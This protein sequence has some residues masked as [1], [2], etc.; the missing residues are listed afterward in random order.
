MA[1]SK[2]KDGGPP[3]A[4]VI[5]KGAGPPLDGEVVGAGALVSDETDAPLAD[6]DGLDAD[7]PAAG[8]DADEKDEDS[9]EFVVSRGYDDAP[10]HDP[11][12][13]TEALDA[14]GHGP[15][16]EDPLGTRLGDFMSAF[17]G[18]VKDFMSRAFDMDG[19]GFVS[20]D[21]GTHAPERSSPVPATTASA[22][23]DLIHDDKSDE[24]L[25]GGP[26]ID[27]IRG[28]KG[29]D[30]LDGA[31]G[32]DWLRGGHGDDVLD[33]GAGSD[34][35]D[36]GK[37][38]DVL[39]Y[40][41]SENAGETDHYD[42][43]KGVDTLRL[44]L[45][46]AEYENLKD[47]LEEL[48]AWIAET[49][50]PK[51]SES[52]GFSDKSAH[53]AKHPV[54]ETSFGLTVRNFE[55]LEVNIVDTEET[56]PEAKADP[57]VVDLGATATAAPVPST[58]DDIVYSDGP[59]PIE[60]ISVTLG[61]DSVINV[62]LDVDVAELP[63]IFDLFMVHDLSGSFYDDLPQVKANFPTL[64]DSLTADYD[65]QFGIGSF[66][67]KPWGSFGSSYYGDYV[68]NTDL[69]VTADKAALMDTMDSLRTY[70]GADWREAQLEAQVQVA[71]H[72][73]EVG[74]R[75][76]AQK[77]V[78]LQTD[79]GYHQEGDYGSAPANN[80]DAVAGE[81]EDYPNAAAVGELLE[82]AGITPIFA[83]ANP[84][85]YYGSTYDTTAIY[86]DLVDTWGFGVVTDL[87]SDSSNI[88]EA[89]TNGLT[90]ADISLDI[91]VNSDDYGYVS[92]VTPSMYEDVG[93]G[94]YTFDITMEI[95]EDGGSYSSDSLT[96]D[97]TGYGTINVEVEIARVDATGDSG[98]DTMLG[99]AGPNGLYGMAGD[100]LLDGRGGDDLLDG[101]TGS[102]VLIGGAGSDTFL[103]TAADSGTDIIKDFQA[104]AGGDILDFSA[105][106]SGFDASDTV[107][108]IVKLVESGG[109]TSVYVD[110]DGAAGAKSFSEVVTLESVTGLDADTMVA[111]GAIALA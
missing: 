100:D 48:D 105:M 92:S 85:A 14:K 40:T 88:V 27:D 29:D 10:V 53:S 8:A 90:S 83:V 103:F 1:R 58:V 91:A 22:R 55:S 45:T 107:A 26:G 77:F 110:A 30:A 35:V 104:E 80:M 16:G 17:G 84:Y 72:E 6:E 36:G 81:W 54:F 73:L 52:H 25:A 15:W 78:V 76:G 60:S 41:L 71:M 95:P 99:G 11:G 31:S 51:R 23:D 63:P 86:Q 37:G 24:T 109:D 98:N 97:I 67:D 3:D 56:A 74:F 101:G 59:L 43:G 19:F 64:Y 18:G 20:P 62:S 66:V 94:A 68:Y 108:N 34:V 82:A 49:A 102:D 79:A 42:G 111:D 7:D 57:V 65:V 70:S 69:T 32:D 106:I 87:A 89:I 96:L 13:A 50:N 9:D 46:A 28:F 47:E 12:S 61:P 39:E 75:D 21:A 38:D 33:G 4:P 5:D 44:N 93:P 2:K